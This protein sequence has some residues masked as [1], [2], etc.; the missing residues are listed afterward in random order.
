MTSSFIT[1]GI[2]RVRVETPRHDSSGITLL[3]LTVEEGIGIISSPEVELQGL[4]SFSCTEA[5]IDPS[6]TTTTHISE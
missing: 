6:E 5:S 2:T 3:L 1:S 4:M